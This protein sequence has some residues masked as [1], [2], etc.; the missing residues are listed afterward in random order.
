[1]SSEQVQRYAAAHFGAANRHM[2][3]A[4]EARIFAA[5]LAP[6][7]PGAVT[8][9]QDALDLESADGNDDRR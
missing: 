9:G 3:V 5:A 8:V 4:G 7:L 1:M 2:V 6:K